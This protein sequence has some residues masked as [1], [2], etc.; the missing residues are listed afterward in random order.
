MGRR[1]MSTG[2]APP[3]PM[4]MEDLKD[5]DIGD[6]TD[7]TMPTNVPRNPDGSVRL[8]GDVPV[9]QAQSIGALDV[10]SA[11]K[12]KAAAVTM[13]EK[14]RGVKNVP[15]NVRDPLEMFEYIKL[16]FPGDWG[17]IIIYV[18]RD[19]PAPPIQFPPVYA[20]SLKDAQALYQYV[21]RHHGQS[22]QSVY[23]IR[24]KTSAGAQRGQ[25]KLY[26]PDRSVR[27]EVEVHHPQQQPYPGHPYQGQPSQY[28][29]P[30]Q[31][32]QQAMPVVVVHNR[33]QQQPQPMM[34]PQPMQAPP[35]AGPDPTQMAILTVL[36]ELVEASRRPAGFIALP[37]DA[38]PIPPGYV[39]VP[40]GMIPG[41][42]MAAYQPPAP[43]AAPVPIPVAAPVAAPPQAA[44]LVIP[45]VERQIQDT[46][47]TMTGVVKA[48]QDMQGMFGM[49]E[50]PAVDSAVEA[51]REEMV[52]SP[53]QT[54]DIGDVK[55][56][57][58]RA[59]GQTDWPSTLLGAAPKIIDSAKGVI[60]TYQKMTAKQAEQAH[61]I[62]QRQL[63]ILEQQRRQQQAPAQAQPQPQPQPQ[64]LPPKPAAAPAPAPTPKRMAVP[65][66]SGPLWG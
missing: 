37:S 64:S 66:P 24:Y 12:N 10:E 29:Y 26:M 59:T 43:A 23:E 45:P 40:G 39:R 35:S 27:P 8:D 65:M 11:A 14:A 6:V 19:E 50:K 41:P 56:V 3:A 61:Q 58:D 31:P 52:E 36:K 63:Q 20:A 48:F 16:A 28:G 34:Q 5:A 54:V 7:L 2:G 53:K 15:W 55:M 47:R 32:P 21:E 46:M 22:P 49:L 51:V 44:P 30:Q 62:Q 18:S 42:P 13:S 9:D 4:N 38:Y 17:A 60:D 25:A 33:D 1:R 57:I